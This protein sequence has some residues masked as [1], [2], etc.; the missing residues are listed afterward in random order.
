M[1]DLT[2]KYFLLFIEKEILEDNT[3]LTKHKYKDKKMSKF[4]EIYVS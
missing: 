4:K 1:R 3:N 2:I